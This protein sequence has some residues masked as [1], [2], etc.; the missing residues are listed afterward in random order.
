M[1]RLTHIVPLVGHVKAGVRGVQGDAVVVT[2]AVVGTEVVVSPSEA[3]EP[4]QLQK[5]STLNPVKDSQLV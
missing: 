5:T 3:A 4:H 2:Q 1:R